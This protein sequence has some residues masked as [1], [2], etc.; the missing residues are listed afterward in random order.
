MHVLNSCF[1][2]FN[3]TKTVFLCMLL[4]LIVIAL[5]LNAGEISGWDHL[6]SEGQVSFCNDDDDDGNDDDDDNDDNDED[7]DNEEVGKVPRGIERFG[8]FQLRRVH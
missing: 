6:S 4:L 8:S 2:V 3:A 5:F 7:D 1:N